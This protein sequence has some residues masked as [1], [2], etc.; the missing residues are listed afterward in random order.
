M[1]FMCN[2]KVLDLNK[3]RSEDKHEKYYALLAQEL[4]KRWNLD[5]GGVVS[6][7][8]PEYLVKYNPDNPRKPDQPKSFSIEYNEV[9]ESGGR[10]AEHCRYYETSVQN[11]KG[12]TKYHPLSEFFDGKMDLTIKHIDKLTF[13]FGCCSSMSGSENESPHKKKYMIVHDPQRKAREKVEIKRKEQLLSKILYAQPQEGGYREDDL[14]KLAAS[15]LINNYKNEDI[16]ILRLS[17]E[18]AVLSDANGMTKFDEFF[19]KESPVDTAYI[20]RVMQEAHDMKLINIHKNAQGERSWRYYDKGRPRRSSII[21]VRGSAKEPIDQLFEYY[22]I[23]DKSFAELEETLEGIK[24]DKPK[25]KAK[26]L[27][28]LPEDG[29]LPSDMTSED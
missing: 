3:I 12:V 26:V 10:G 27:A 21:A 14:R 6:I 25:P 13:L 1:A 29:F 9:V 7:V 5:K 2:G 28:D 8:Y 17:I 24:T 20:R 22:T 16:D 4:I 19:D 18:N 15:L 23:H 11:D